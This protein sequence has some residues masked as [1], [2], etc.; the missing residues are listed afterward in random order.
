M[1]SYRYIS[2][3]FPAL[4][5]GQLSI[6]VALLALDKLHREKKGHALET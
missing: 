4:V 2:S 6:N 1:L 5:E 3:L